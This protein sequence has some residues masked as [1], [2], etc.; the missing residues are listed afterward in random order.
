MSQPGWGAPPQQ[1]GQPQQG[2]WGQPPQQ[3]YPP[4]GGGNPWGPPPQQA[5]Q[6]PARQDTR[7]ANDILMGGGGSPA[8]KFEGPGVRKVARIVKPPQSKQER[9]YVPNQPGAGKPKF[10]PSG[11]P[12]MGVTVEVQ[13][14]ERDPQDQDDDGKRTFYIEGKRL[15]EAVREAVKAAGGPGLE[16][17]GTLDVTLTHYDEPNDRKSGCNWQITYTLPGNNVLMDQPPQQQFTQPSGPPQGQP[18]YTQDPWAG[19][20][21]QPPQQGMTPEQQA[22]YAAWQGGAPSYDE[23]PF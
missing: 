15:K 2:G 17:G 7:S 12:I 1:Y 9:E 10:F 5:Q 14:N 16:V 4:Q 20:Q 6:Q 13:T 21:Q 19:Q 22:A 11:D 18:Q 23:P 8:W 3:Q